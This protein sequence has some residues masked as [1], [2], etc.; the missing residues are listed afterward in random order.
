[1]DPVK[2]KSKV[3]DLDGFNRE[4]AIFVYEAL[5]LIDVAVPTQE[6]K[7]R[8]LSKNLKHDR[9][10]SNKEIF[11]QQITGWSR[12]DKV[13]DYC[14]DF[15]LRKYRK[16]KGTYAS[17]SMSTGI[18]AINSIY[19]DW[20]KSR[21]HGAINLARTLWH[22]YQHSNGFKHPWWPRRHYRLSVPH[23]SGNTLGE[24]LE[25]HVIQGYNLTPLKL[26]VEDDRGA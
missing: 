7:T 10:M 16:K 3:L 8:F 25:L 2:L 23:Q 4:D 26:P 18:I 22:E 1:M 19:F 24:V 20:C 6:Y 9:G 12:F 13:A 21:R 17:T 15:T 5:R 14:L 11:E